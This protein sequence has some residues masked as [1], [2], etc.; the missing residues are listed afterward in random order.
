V[1]LRTKRI[2]FWVG[3]S[4]IALIGAGGLAWAGF[5]GWVLYN[6]MGGWG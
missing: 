2:L 1:K 6:M 4:A 3:A 5:W